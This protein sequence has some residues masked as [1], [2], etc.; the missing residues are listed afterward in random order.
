MQ[1]YEINISL[2]KKKFLIYYIHF[3]ICTALEEN[4]NN[5]VML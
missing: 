4:K 3:T 5:H 2:S 1:R